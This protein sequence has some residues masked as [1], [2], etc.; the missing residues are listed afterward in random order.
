MRIESMARRGKYA[1]EIELLKGALEK[2]EDE[3][4]ELTRALENRE[5]INEYAHQ[6]AAPLS[7][8]PVQTQSAVQYDWQ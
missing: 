4:R 5:R 7:A 6:R 1:S 3:I 2:T 8:V